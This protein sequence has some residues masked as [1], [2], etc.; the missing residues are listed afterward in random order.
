M[1]SPNVVLDD[2]NIDME[3]GRQIDR[4]RHLTIIFDPNILMRIARLFG[5]RCPSTILPTI[6]SSVV[7][8]VD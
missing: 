7:D 8:P 3:L 6:V 2:M 1:L 4:D 5:W